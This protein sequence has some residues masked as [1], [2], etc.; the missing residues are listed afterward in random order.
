M[1]ILEDIRTTKII[2]LPSFKDSKIVIYDQ[3]LGHQNNELVDCNDYEA[4][5]KTL[6]FLI[7]E[8][9]FVG[10]DGNPMPINEESLGMLPS[11]DLTFMFQ[12]IAKIAILRENKKKENLKK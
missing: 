3:L 1:P 8:W 9:N 10:K 2:E 12:E 7:K 6:K 11:S 4:G 5:I